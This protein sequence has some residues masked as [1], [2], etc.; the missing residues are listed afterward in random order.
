MVWQQIEKNRNKMAN[1]SGEYEQ[2]K[3]RVIELDRLDPVHYR[4]ERVG[5]S[6]GKYPNDAFRMEG[7]DE[8]LER[9]HC[10]PSHQNISD[11]RT[12]VELAGEE[13]LESDAYKSGCPDGP[14]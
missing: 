10:K 6:A 2:V 4:P 14:K 9:E 12:L 3:Y 13:K 7:G 11:G 8:G 1:A 5:K